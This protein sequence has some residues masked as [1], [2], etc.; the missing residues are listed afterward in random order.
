M[1]DLKFEIAQEVFEVLPEAYFGVVAV[2]NIDNSLKFPEISERLENTI[3]ECQKKYDGIKIK[4]SE[5]IRPYRDA[6]KKIG[7]NPNRYQCSIEALL[8]R[9]VK[10]KG[11]TKIN[12]VVDLVNAISLEYQVPIGAHDIDTVDEKLCVRYAEE[13]DIFIPFGNGNMEIPEEKEIIYVSGRQVRTRRWIWRQSEIGM[14][15]DK[16]KNI[17]FPIDGF[18]NENRQRVEEASMALAEGI[19]KYFRASAQVG[20][21][22]INSRSFEV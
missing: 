8:D 17:L 20:R 22:D 9:T 2:K 21:I 1:S 15:T 13:G 5:E 16:T 18:V 4:E 3:C 7:I 6:F 12:G 14:I 19:V 11:V 10:G